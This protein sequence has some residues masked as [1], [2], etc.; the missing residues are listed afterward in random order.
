ML[1]VMAVTLIPGSVPGFY[2][3]ADRKLRISRRS[4]RSARTPG[5]K[6]HGWQKWEA[7]ADYGTPQAHTVA[8]APTLDGLRKKLDGA[9][10]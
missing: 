9:S 3:T 6:A 4:G 10:K 7:V 5:R 8:E 1:N 2:Y